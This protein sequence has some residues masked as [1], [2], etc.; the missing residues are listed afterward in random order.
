[1]SLISRLHHQLESTPKDQYVEIRTSTSMEELRRL[2]NL[3]NIPLE[4]LKLVERL[5]DGEFG[6]LDMEENIFYKNARDPERGFSTYGGTIMV[7]EDPE[8]KS[9][10]V[11]NIGGESG[12]TNNN[13]GVPGVKG[14]AGEVTYEQVLA[15]KRV[16]FAS[17]KNVRRFNELE[18]F[19]NLETLRFD[20]CSELEELSLPYM[21]LGGY[22]NWIIFCSKLRK[23][24]TRYGLDVVGSH[25]LRGNSK[26][27]ELDTSNWTISSSNTERM[28]EG[29]SSL[30][31]LDLRNIEMDN[32]TIALN[33]FSGCSSLQSLDTSK[34][35]LGN[36]SNG[37]SMFSGCSSLQSLDT[38]KWNLGNLSSG[39]SMFY[40]CSFLQ[41]LDTSKWNLGNLSN[42]SSMFYG[43]SFLQ[44]LDT[45]K[46]NLGNLS[47]GS[48]MFYGCSSLQSLDT[49]KWN[50][51]NLSNGSYMFYGCSSLQSLDTSKWNL[52]NLSNGSSMF[53]GCSS[54]QSL[55]TSKW[56]LGNLNT[57]ENMFRQTKI[58]TLDVRDWDLRKLTNTVYMF[59]LTPLISL[60]TS[61]WRLNNLSTAGQMFERCNAL[62]SLGDTSRWGL[63]KL[64]NASAMFNGCSAL[65][66]LDTSG[67]RLENVTTMRQTFDSCIALTTLG[68]TSRWNLIRCTDMQNLFIGCTQLVKVDIS[69]S[70]T[71]MVVVSNLSNTTWQ[72]NNLESLVGDH[73]EADNVSVFNGYN[74]T[75][76]E[77]G[78]VVNLNLASILAIIRGLG[79]N[80]T[81][82]KF[83]LPSGFDKSRIPQ[84]YK[85]MLE[86]KNWE[87]V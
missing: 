22:A 37:S 51:G 81:K 77:F 38:S 30:T 82:R 7:F 87:L 34:W 62:I 44:S 15:C 56:N 31:R 75:N 67:W 8:V 83:F 50:L 18:Y 2:A 86:N 35:N 19:R 43:C 6:L 10:L 59:Y 61:G 5:V 49:S 16:D 45:S 41:S 47:N 48:S 64:T 74:S 60:D 29:C 65:Q 28:F 53:S 69:Y 39:S 40:G 70:S 21:S 36:L 73:T 33:M 52:G 85:T 58:T 14:V 57:A 76:F 55:D 79:T 17:N 9:Y 71:P 11:K 84:E 26:L 66:S 54:L 32:V 42:G 1:M 68:D 80:R 12:I 13:Y 23:I 72:V 3:E 63:E 24:T 20:G 4:R 78:N 46:W 27:S 25:I